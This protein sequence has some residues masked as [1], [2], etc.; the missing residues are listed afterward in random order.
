MKK[1]LLGLSVVA[2][3]TL[4]LSGTANSNDINI[5]FTANIR[6]TTCDMKLVGGSG[7]DT[8][9]T[10]KI[11]DSEGKV[12]IDQVRAGN[13]TASFKLMIVECPSTLTALKTTVKGTQSGYIPTVIA[14]RIKGGADYAG[15]SIARASAPT[16]PFTINS[17]NDNER[18]VWSQDEINNKEVPLVATLRETSNNQLTTGA[19]EAL[20]TFEFVYE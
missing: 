1:N 18:L 19:F 8:Q 5:N 3:T 14:N 12:R 10:L 17:T 15:V 11:G 16:A 13:A 6:E 20:A 4:A 2:I 9:Q 7:T